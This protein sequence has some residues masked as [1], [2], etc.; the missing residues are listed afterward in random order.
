MSTAF[1]APFNLATPGASFCPSMTA[2]SPNPIDLPGY[3]VRWNYKDFLTREPDESGAAFWTDPIT[4]CG[5]DAGC[6]DVRRVHTSAAFFL[7]IEFQETGYLAYRT[8][9]TAFGDATSPNVAGTVPVIRFDE[10]L[11]DAR[12]IGEGVVVNAGDWQGR[13]EAN[14]NNYV[15]EF[16]SRRRFLDAFPASMTAEQF[17]GKLN[18][19]AGDVLSPHEREQLVAQLEAEPDATQGRA[20]ALRKIAE[21]ADLRNNEKNRAFVLMQYYGYLRRDPDGPPDTDFRGWGF[22]LAKLNQFGGDFVQA[23]MVKAFVSSEEY[24]KRFG[25]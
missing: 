3:F 17:V 13:L 7:S 2:Q 11:A 12:R 6:V 10:F 19:N 21:D 18:E 8:Y 9:K 15:L 14:K 16:V 5:S 24:R 25:Q 23:E 22:W 20:S 1:F 4:Q